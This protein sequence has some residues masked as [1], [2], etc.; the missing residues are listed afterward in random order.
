MDTSTD[1]ACPF[2]FL[3]IFFDKHIL[4]FNMV[5]FINFSFMVALSVYYF[6]YHK[7]S[8]LDSLLTDYKKSPIFLR[9]LLF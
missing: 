3:I 9:D 6:V 5:K 1:E 8:V 7:E 4:N 2:G